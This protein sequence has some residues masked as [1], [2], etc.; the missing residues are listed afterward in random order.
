MRYV[1]YIGDR[2]LEPMP[3]DPS[4]LATEH[5]SGTG[6]RTR[7]LA[8]VSSMV[9]PGAGHILMGQRRKGA[10]LLGIFLVL[11]I[12]FWPA[13]LPR[14]Y[15]GFVALYV[16][17]ICLYLYAV[18]A[19]LLT[20]SPANRWRLRLWLIA[21]VPLAFTIASLFATLALRVSGFRVMEVPS[22]SME[23]TLLAGDH[24]VVDT[25]CFDRKLPSHQ[26]VIIFRR[27]SIFY[28]KRVIG[29]GGDV[30]GGNNGAILI[31]GSSRDESYVQHTGRPPVWMNNFGPLIIPA[32]E[33]FVMGDNRDVSLDS[34]SAEFGLVPTSAIVG[35]PLYVFRTDRQGRNIH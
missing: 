19:T 25:R 32:G 8:V 1:C 4:T 11:L 35:A 21:L 10:T 17:C 33:Y 12:C 23:K 16:L 18:C 2:M 34:R 14:Y 31:N 13:R 28:V 22:T 27:K 24:I 15:A 29:V 30:I 6:S 26:D 3:G 7:W 9:V 5:E 20:E